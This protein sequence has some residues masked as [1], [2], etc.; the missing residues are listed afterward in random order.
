MA[1]SARK[2]ARK[3]KPFKKG[4]DPRRGR[5]PAKGAPN[6]GRPPN[7]FKAMCRD[8]ASLGAMALLAKKVMKNPKHPAFL[9]AL[10]WATEHGYGKAVQPISGPH[11][12]PIP[13]SVKSAQV[14]VPD[15]GRKLNP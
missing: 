11:G 14:Y 8:V 13:V 4:P 9:T 6:A 1:K 15:N 12:G 10:R 7:E 5:G 3:G 2:S